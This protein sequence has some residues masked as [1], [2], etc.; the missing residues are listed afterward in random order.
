[1]VIC[2]R[3]TR[4]SDFLRGQSWPLKMVV[5][6]RI[7]YTPYKLNSPSSP[8][9][10]FVNNMADYMGACDC[11]I[12]KAGPGTIAEAMICGVPIVLNG[13]FD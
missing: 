6:V 12:S 9:K 7:Y 5:K 8:D 2:G 4:L 13:K 1:M 10:G 3:N 11:V